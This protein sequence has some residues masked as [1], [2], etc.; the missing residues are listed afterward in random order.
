M[1]IYIVHCDGSSQRKISIKTL[2][3]FL[4]S[5]SLCLDIEDF[6]N[7]NAKESQHCGCL[8][9]TVHGLLMPP[10]GPRLWTTPYANV[11]CVHLRIAIERVLHA[12]SNRSFP[13]QIW[14]LPWFSTGQ[15]I[16][17]MTVKTITLDVCVTCHVFTSAVRMQKNHASM[18]NNVYLYLKITIYFQCFSMDSSGF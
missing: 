3:W 5:S 16:T 13:V 8:T 9:S 10:I 12:S 6:T 7:P 15:T 17:A 11:P 2:H 1:A 18:Y 14:A 4:C